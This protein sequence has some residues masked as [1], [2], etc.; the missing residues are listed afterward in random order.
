MHK[1]GS[2]HLSTSSLRDRRLKGKGSGVLDAS[3][4]DWSLRLFTD[5]EQLQ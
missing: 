2:F 4:T 3:N 5:N 1:S